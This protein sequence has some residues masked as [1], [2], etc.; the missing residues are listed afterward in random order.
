MSFTL[1][2]KHKL[3]CFGALAL[4][5]A[6]LLSV[7]ALHAQTRHGHSL[8]ELT[9]ALE[10]QRRLG[11]AETL[12]ASLDGDAYRALTAATAGGPAAAFETLAATVADRRTGLQRLLQATTA[13]HLAPAQEALRAS[14]AANVDRYAQEVAALVLL[15]AADPQSAHAQ[16]AG[17]ETRSVALAGEFERLGRSIERNARN[18]LSGAVA[19]NA[20]TAR[21]LWTALAVA[22]LVS[23][24]LSWLLFRGAYL[25]L[26]SIA[27]HLESISRGTAD[28]TIRLDDSGRDEMAWIA[29]SFNRFVKRIRVAMQS[30]IESSDGLGRAATELAAL[31]QRSDSL[32]GEQQREVDQL[33]VAMQQMEGAVEH[34]AENSVHTAGAVERTSDEARAVRGV[35][36][37]VLVSFQS[38]AT[39]VTSAAEVIRQLERDTTLIG[40]VLDVIR[41][42]AEQTNLLALN[43]AIEAARAGDQGRGFA[44]VADEVRTLASRTQQSTAEIRGTIERLQERARHAVQVI[45]TSSG[46]AHGAMQEAGAAQS[47]LAN[48]TDQVDALVRMNTQIASAAEEQRTVTAEVRKNIASINDETVETA[49]LARRVAGA[50]A[51]LRGLSGMLSTAITQFRVG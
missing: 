13:P 37:S 51:G 1:T 32:L 34:I 35:V 38:M 18:T 20:A 26:E 49:D 28:L 4:A 9:G 48:I 14:A 47:A 3:L 50:A 36:D 27:L 7:L 40:S 39:Q 16:A 8:A 41:G 33:A 10:A 5:N 46:H 42:I 12:L 44:V 15:A 19:S 30:V 22:M 21:M 17:F 2:F 24:A 25:P 11:R 6:A 31:S 43:A 29:G 45:E 23:L